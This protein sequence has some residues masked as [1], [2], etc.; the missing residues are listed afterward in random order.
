VLAGIKDAALRPEYI[1]TVAGWLSIDDATIRDEVA[2]AGGKQT[3]NRQTATRQSAPRQTMPP[4]SNDSITTQRPA[5]AAAGVNNAVGA[6]ERTALK[7]VLQAPDQVGEWFG[8]LEESVFT[9]PAAAAVYAACAK[10]GNPLDYPDAN[11]WV[12]AVIEVSDEDTASQVRALSVEP[13]PVDRPDERYVQAVLARVLE[14]DAG[15]RIDEIKGVLQRSDLQDDAAEQE[16]LLGDLLA[17]E[18]YRRAMRE[19][20]VGDLA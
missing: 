9:V 15:R 8:S 13:L 10:A 18:Q 11:K 4:Q 3:A 14:L 6:V 19:F 7:C 12:Q 16:R 2:K 17:L 20:A 5:P 1:R